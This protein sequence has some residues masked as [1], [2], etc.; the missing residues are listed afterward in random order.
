M[1][2]ENIQVD[3]DDD[4]NQEQTTT[5]Q[6]K[7]AIEVGKQLALILPQALDQLVPRILETNR[8]PELQQQGFSSDSSLD[9]RLNQDEMEWIRFDP[10][11]TQLSVK[12]ARKKAKKTNKKCEE[13]QFNPEPSTQDK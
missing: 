10:Y 12:T 6:E 13:I 2:E 4:S 11:P 7:I 5:F 9:L 1:T 8:P 3:T